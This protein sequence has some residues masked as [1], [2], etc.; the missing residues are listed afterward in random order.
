MKTDPLLHHAAKRITPN[1]LEQVLEVFGLLGC[2]MM[3]RPDGARWAMIGQDGIP[4]DIQLVEVAETPI[5]SDTRVSSHIAFISESP[6][7]QVARVEKWAY[8]RNVQFEKGSW[9]KNELWFD[10]PNLF[11]DFVIEIMHVGVTEV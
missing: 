8:E 5:R 6:L 10:L 4:F 11:V 3:F 1:S 7:T 2:K 9:N